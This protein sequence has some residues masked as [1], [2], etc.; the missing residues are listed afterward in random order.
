MGASYAQNQSQGK[1]RSAQ[2]TLVRPAAWVL[3]VLALLAVLGR[4]RRLVVVHDVHVE[5]CCMWPKGSSLRRLCFVHAFLRP[6]LLVL[7]VGHLHV[8]RCRFMNLSLRW[9]SFRFHWVQSGFSEDTVCFDRS[10]LLVGQY[11]R[12]RSCCA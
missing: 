8:V 12:V 1:G 2:N 10:H 7:G 6:L 9:L 4:W 3:T 5:V 11:V